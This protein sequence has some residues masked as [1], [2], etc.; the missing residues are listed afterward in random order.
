MTE[1]AINNHLLESAL[2]DL[3]QQG[4]DH[5]DPVRFAYIQSMVY[6]SKNHKYSVRKITDIKVFKIL[7]ELQSDFAKAQ[8]SAA[9]TIKHINSEYSGMSEKIQALFDY[10][11]FTAI[12]HLLFKLEADKKRCSN[13][14]TILA[15]KLANASTV[16]DNPNLDFDKLLQLQG[17]NPELSFTHLTT[18][19]SS[20][21]QHHLIDELKSMQ[22]FR[23]SRQK[24]NS[25]KLVT[26]SINDSPDEP[27]PL[28]PQMLAIRSLSL[29]RELSP[30]Y[31]NRFVS[32]IETL[33]WLET[34]DEKD[35]LST[36]QKHTRDGRKKTRAH[37]K[38]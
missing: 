29:M 32:Y 37:K 6:R 9:K 13:S 4:I 17:E 24:L 14:I 7:D 18:D 12:R 22:L 8:K 27:G 33:L 25:D 16:I 31:L 2:K 15:D 11:D 21:A 10:G 5:F 30:L 26:Q 35:K 36:P 23:E 3:R 34:I 20:L 28:N 1:S 38:T 19:I